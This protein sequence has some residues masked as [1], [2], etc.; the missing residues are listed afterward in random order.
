MQAV[1]PLNEVEWAQESLIVE[2]NGEIFYASPGMQKYLKVQPGKSQCN[3]I[4]L[5]ID[6]LRISLQTA[7]QQAQATGRKIVCDDLTLEVDGQLQRL[8]L[9]VQPMQ[10]VAGDRSL[11]WVVFRECTLPG[12]RSEAG[13]DRFHRETQLSSA[14]HDPEQDNRLTAI[15]N[16]TA[17][18]I[19]GIDLEGRC[20]FA[21]ASCARLLGYRHPDDLVGQ[22]MPTLIHPRLPNGQP[23][24]FAD[25][26]IYRALQA[27]Q[28]LHADDEVYRR[29]DGTSFDVEIW[30]YPQVHAG[31][32]AGGVVSF[33]DIT[34]RKM[35]LSEL[36]DREAHL[37]RVI[38]HTLGFIGVLDVQ[39]V[40]H[41]VNQTALAAGGISRHEVIGK[42]FWECCWWSYNEQVVRDLQAAIA[43]AASGDAVRYDVAVRL[44]GDER[45]AIDLMLAPIMDARGQVTYL[46]FSGVDIS[47]RKLAE[48]EV[49]QRIKQ[50]NLA[51]E[52]GR[53]GLWEWDMAA[54]RVTWSTQMYETY[55]YT[56]ATFSPTR[57]GFIDIIHPDDRSKLEELIKSATETLCHNHEVEFRVIKGGTGE[58][59]WTHCRGTVRRDND[60]TA[61]S[62]LSVSVDITERKQRELTLAFL[63]E[64][65]SSL[66]G[67]LTAEAIV[68][69]ASR[70]VTNYLSLSHFMLV[71]MD[72]V[73]A[74]TIVEFDYCSDDSRN[75][76]GVCELTNFANDRELKQL[77]AGLP[78]VVNDTAEPIRSAQ[79]IEGFAKLNIGAMLNAPSSREQRRRFM[80][81]A[82]KRQ[83]HVWREDEVN[84]LRTLA[85]ILRLKLDRARAEDALRESESRFRDLADNIS[86]FAWMTDSTG[87]VFWYN[88]RWLDF[89]G[90]QAESLPNGGW[91]QNLHPEHRARVVRHWQE[92]LTNGSVWEDTFPLR[93]RDGEYRWFLSHAQPI[94]D[95]DGKIV[96]WFGTNTDITKTKRAE[97]ALLASQE[98][99]RLG[100]EVAEFA[101]ARIDYEQ[102]SVQLTS[103]AAQLYGL[104]EEAMVATRSDVH[105]TFHADDRQEL[106]AS[107][108]HCLDPANRRDFAH[109]HRVVHPDG[110]LRWL[111][112]RKRVAF[113]QSVD[114][115]RP[116][117]S[118]LAAQDITEE[119]RW[120]TELADRESHLRRVINN[121]LGLVGVID[122]NGILVEVDDRWMQIAGLE[123]DEVIGKHFADCAWWTYDEAVSATMRESMSRAFAGETVRYDLVLHAQNDERLIVDFMIA[124]VRDIDGSVTHLITS[125]V[126]ISERKLAEQQLAE[127]KERLS[128]AMASARMGS[129][130]WEPDSDKIIW[131]AQHLAI[132]GLSKEQATGADFWKLIHAEDAAANQIAI[133]RTI[134]GLS[135]YDIEFRIVRPDGKVRWLAARGKVVKADGDRPLRFVGMNWDITESKEQEQRIRASEERL[136]N[137]A[138]AA[139]FGTVHVDLV[140]STIFYS[141]ELRRLVGMPMDEEE[142]AV[143]R[144]LPAWIHPEDRAA[145][146]M[147]Y[148]Q[149]A[150]LQ[151]GTTAKIDHRILTPAGQ[152]RWV[153]MQSK[154]VY[155]GVGEQRKAT[156]LIGTVIDI[157]PQREFEQSLMEARREAEAANQSKSEFL[158]NMS[159]EIRTPMTAI[160]GYT[161]LIAEEIDDAEINQHLRTIRRNGDFL[162]EIINDILDL[163]KIEAGKFEVCHQRFSPQQLVEDVRSIME[164]R[165]ADNKIDLEVEY[166]GQIPEQ[167][168]SDPK[169]LRQ[170]LINL[171]G[172]AIKFTPAGY[173]RILVSYAAAENLL[174]FE[175]VDS[176]IG[177]SEQ[178]SQRLFQPFS[179]GDGN[180]NR[181]FGGTGLGLAISKRLTE[182]LGGRISFKSQLGKGSTFTATIAIGS[183]RELVMVTPQPISQ[184]ALS[185]AADTSVCLSCHVLI[186]DDRR[187]IR[188]LSKRFLT[189]V[190]ATV[191]EAEDGEA[192]IEKVTE[193]MRHG[194]SFDLI[195][196]DM[197]MP[198]LDGYSTA[199][200]LRNLGFIKPIVALTADAMQGDMHRCLES[201]C[202]DYLSKPIDRTLLLNLV[203]NLTKS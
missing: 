86:Q 33:L 2:S 3:L 91:E 117:Q 131:D 192:A 21:N 79:Q 81:C 172:N 32:V 123:R 19:Y 177:I 155:T 56:P 18:G 179:Q 85:D 136:R 173:V 97:E 24:P 62:I 184:L 174:R 17:E 157:T 4:A 27:G 82:T 135:D 72:K 49:Q 39:G 35:L 53:M 153:R 55:G 11:L 100:I 77:N 171:V 92:C 121:Q 166:C 23:R 126:D 148:Q 164:V 12:N 61:L 1:P 88:Q 90:T 103:Q 151:E 44:A 73:T 5:A 114:P 8:N 93:S 196:L 140:R 45:L 145:C 147:H 112:V 149:L 189:E 188:F 187:D 37:R 130:E 46:I 193:A 127:S 83:P 128:M 116:L 105:A 199:K 159:H 63:A 152:V 64:L 185:D 129:Y 198:K 65:Q 102:D 150:S 41:E 60:G 111:K 119:K 10:R 137:A 107:I 31:R 29:K 15:L 144:G 120:K 87:A 142:L 170:I 132:T 178:Q 197:Q 34:E 68:G 25:C 13:G 115:P 22:C 59:I 7:L 48:G 74:E 139:G 134:A 101:L 138:E 146:A 20:T 183:D 161:D 51:L 40:L 96:R 180:V 195:L 108:R 200:A 70:R 118:I 69:E 109:E 98:Q 182:M 124:P 99:L 67:C 165:A 28:S 66:T 194:D 203:S 169:R 191:D 84:L 38:D 54:D 42:P 154:P 14:S 190:G 122:R 141:R 58:T 176:G 125:G 158:A 163:S 168:E 43:K 26:K 186:V 181:K 71:R 80:V 94:R 160:L 30:S 104:G 50:L 110:S 133:Q 156:Q 162:L 9:T 47:E 78:M 201:G 36:T 143:L 106:L 52:S 175:V 167:I 89:T 57:A 113:D 75:L 6:E 76:V 16:S 95:E 202:N